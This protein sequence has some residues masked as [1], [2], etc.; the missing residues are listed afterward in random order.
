MGSPPA[1]G[2]ADYWSAG[3][4]NIICS[5]CGT[6]LKFSQAVRNWQGMWRHPKCNEPRHPQDFVHA[7]N[8]QEMAIPY[9]QYP[10]EID[11]NVNLQ[12]LLSINP[13][14]ISGT[15]LFPNIATQS[16]AD[17]ITQS[18]NTLTPQTSLSVTALA[19]A[20]YPDWVIPQSFNWTWVSGGAGITIGGQG[21]LAIAFNTASPPASGVIQCTVIST[22]G[23]VGVATASVF[24]A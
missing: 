7:R 6:K 3:D 10:G 9:P 16:F 21:T 15:T 2:A 22:L 18:G 23:A 19:I 5:V 17:I 14:I 4:W 11:I 24:L 12:F 13:P 8:A 1:R 20:V